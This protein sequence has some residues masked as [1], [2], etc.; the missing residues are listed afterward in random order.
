MASTPGIMEVAVVGAGWMG[1]GI[2]MVCSLGGYP[3]NLVDLSQDILDRCLK[4]VRHDLDL[5]VEA[6]EISALDADQAMARIRTTSNLA[7]GLARSELAIEAV[8][9]NLEMKQDVFVKMEAVARPGT[10][11]A[12]NASSTPT[13]QIAARCARPEQVVG[14]H[15][16]EPP[17]VLRAVEVIRGER[18]SD[19]TFEKAAA[20]VESI[21]SVP[22]RVYKDQR[23]FVI[24][25]L[26]GAMRKAADELIQAG[27]TTEEEI[28]KAARYSFGPKYAATGPGA[29]RVG[30]REHQ[31]EE[32]PLDEMGRRALLMLQVARAARNLD[33]PA[34][35]GKA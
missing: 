19:E 30:S 20:F 33:E 9:E 35:R 14:I 1:S 32:E 15:V 26:Q 17:Y 12:S 29:S 6:E 21:G 24:N 4:K 25:Y 22:I 18:T 34:G 7:E 5:L 13:T 8:P 28:L 3:V 16:F 23:S 11:L 10:I 31:Y 2:T 27:V